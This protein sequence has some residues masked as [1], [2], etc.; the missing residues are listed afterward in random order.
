MSMRLTSVKMTWQHLGGATEESTRVLAEI[1]NATSYV[2][3]GL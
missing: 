3:L 1:I 2:S